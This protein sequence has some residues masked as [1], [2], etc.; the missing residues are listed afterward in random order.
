MTL[1][2]KNV[3]PE[4]ETE[5]RAR[6]QASGQSLEQVALAALMAGMSTTGLDEHLRAVI[7][8]WVDDPDFD[9]A[10]AEFERVDEKAWR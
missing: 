7:G 4:V 1:I 6:A 8:T 2:L 9:A 3:P 5:M 10:V